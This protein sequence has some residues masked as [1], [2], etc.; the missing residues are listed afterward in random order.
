M[1]PEPDVYGLAT[2][3][4]EG[5]KCFHGTTYMSGVRKPELVEGNWASHD[6]KLSISQMEV[7]HFAQSAAVLCFASFA[8]SPIWKTMPIPDAMCHRL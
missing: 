5:S 6:S 3:E 7:V 1:S 4:I 2:Y 8:I